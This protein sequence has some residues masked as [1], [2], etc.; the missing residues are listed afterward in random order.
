LTCGV[1]FHRE[2]V[3]MQWWTLK[4]YLGAGTLELVSQSEAFDV[5]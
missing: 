1:K 3:K 5:R 2:G 4:L